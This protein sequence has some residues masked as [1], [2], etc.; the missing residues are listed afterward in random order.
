MS[1]EVGKGSSLQVCVNIQV[2]TNPY[3]KWLSATPRQG[4]RSAS[5]LLNP[6]RPRIL[7]PVLSSQVNTMLRWSVHM[8]NECHI[9]QFARKTRKGIVVNSRIAP[10]SGPYGLFR[11]KH[12]QVLTVNSQCTR[13]W[14]PADI[15]DAVGGSTG[16]DGTVVLGSG[17]ETARALCNTATLTSAPAVGRTGVD[18]CGTAGQG[19]GAGVWTGRVQLKHCRVWES[20][21]SR[22]ICKTP[23]AKFTR[24]GH[25]LGHSRMFTGY[26]SRN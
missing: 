1:R 3:E 15:G 23:Y 16:N 8:Y 9:Y 7:W 11:N 17:G 13:D 2:L 20:C 22:S 14:R 24:Y 26:Q 21:T 10:L 4:S 6:I 5:N 25:W 12:T 19:H 18:P